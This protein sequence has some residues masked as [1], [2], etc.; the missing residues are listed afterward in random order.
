MLGRET[1][2]NEGAE[3]DKVACKQGGA[4]GMVQGGKGAGGAQG[5]V[6]GGPRERRRSAKAAGGG[7]AAGRR[8]GRGAAVLGGCG[9]EQGRGRDWRELVRVLGRRGGG[10]EGGT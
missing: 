3:G 8:D 7:P 4:L 9:G 2:A 1:G 5:E 6:A 10:G